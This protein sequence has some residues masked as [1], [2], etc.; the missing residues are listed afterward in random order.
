MLDLDLRFF[1]ALN[2]L[3]GTFLRMAAGLSEKLGAFPFMPLA[4]A[5][6]L[7]SLFIPR[8]AIRLAYNLWW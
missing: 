4:L 8:F 5:L 2:V 7:V 3:D 6:S 1:S